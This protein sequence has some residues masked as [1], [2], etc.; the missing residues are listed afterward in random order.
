MKKMGSLILVVYNLLM[1]KVHLKKKNHRTISSSKETKVEE[2][3]FRR[4]IISDSLP[5]EEDV[6]IQEL[7]A[8]TVKKK[9]NKEHHVF[10]SSFSELVI[11]IFSLRHF[12]LKMAIMVMICVLYI[13]IGSNTSTFDK[14]NLNSICNKVIFCDTFPH[15]SSLKTDSIIQ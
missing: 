14:G 7:L 9:A 4:L 15:Q 8:A 6:L 2:V 1:V 10:K 11:S 13:S 5:F 3:E 12:E